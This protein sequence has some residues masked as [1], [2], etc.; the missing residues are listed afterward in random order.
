MWDLSAGAGGRFYIGDA[1]VDLSTVRVSHRC[2][3]GNDVEVGLHDV[4]R[5]HLLAPAHVQAV[6]RLQ[7]V[8]VHHCS[9]DGVP[10]PLPLS[11]LQSLLMTV[12]RHRSVLGR[13]PSPLVVINQ[14]FVVVVIIVDMVPTSK[15]KETPRR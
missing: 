4:R 2:F 8:Q 15:T 12:M 1:V 14:P 5:R 3:A 9:H 10:S 6:E 7:A 11:S 13:K